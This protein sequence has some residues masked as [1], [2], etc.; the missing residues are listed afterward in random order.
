MN[1]DIFWSQT[2]QNSCAIFAFA[3]LAV[4]FDRWWIALFALLFINYFTVQRKYYRVCDEC[5]KH[6][7]YANNYNEALNLAKES[8]WKHYMA[9]NTDYCPDCQK[10][11]HTHELV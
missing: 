3:T 1:K 5:G 9:A 10:E 4:V 11:R 6:S 2:I 8:G 7:P